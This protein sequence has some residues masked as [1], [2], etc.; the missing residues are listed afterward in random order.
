MHFL[1]PISFRI[2]TLMW[3]KSLLYLPWLQKKQ[4]KVTNFCMKQSFQVE[5]YSLVPKLSDTSVKAL[6]CADAPVVL[7]STSSSSVVP[8]VVPLSSGPKHSQSV[9]DAMLVPSSKICCKSSEGL[10]IPEDFSDVWPLSLDPSYVGLEDKRYYECQAEG[11]S[12]T[13]LGKAAFWSH[14][15][16][17]H[18]CWKA[19]CPSCLLS[20]FNPESLRKHICEAHPSLKLFVKPCGQTK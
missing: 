19:S 8:T 2:E 17:F 13:S 20:S 12:Y 7:P 18:T 10:C 16:Q 11:C 9:D 14:V 1:I 15:A 3:S 5:T 4:P 6:L